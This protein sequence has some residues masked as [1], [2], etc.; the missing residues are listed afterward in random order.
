MFLSLCWQERIA[1]DYLL[2]R[3]RLFGAAP[4]G[5][6]NPCGSTSVLH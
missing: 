5:L 1:I 2:D 4:D 3:D 6:K